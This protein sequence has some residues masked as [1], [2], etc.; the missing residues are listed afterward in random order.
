M[1]ELRTVLIDKETKKISREHFQ[2]LDGV[3]PTAE[4]IIPRT[5]VM[6]LSDSDVVFWEPFR[7]SL[8]TYP[9][10]LAQI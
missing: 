10:K 8:R 6:P 9:K 1:N 3:L 7:M 2:L 5:M 4:M